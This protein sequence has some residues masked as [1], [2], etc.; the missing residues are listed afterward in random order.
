[1]QPDRGILLLAAASLPDPNFDHT[2]VLL[3]DHADEQGSFGLVL[4]HRTTVKLRDVIEGEGEWNAP[5]YRGGPVQLNSLHF[6]HRGCDQ[7]PEA[8]ELV[9]GLYWGR[10]FDSVREAFDKG[11]ADPADF[12][13]F[14]GYSGWG[15]QQL[16]GELKQES[17]Y[18][19]QATAELVFDE[20]IKN[21]WRNAFRTLGP[22]YSILSTFPDNCMLN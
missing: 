14:A 20:D 10:D 11:S 8:I 2:V 16:S 3:C 17:W 7:D 19:A 1:M 6:L 22:D 15:E 5:L 4:N 21:Q 12:R 13:F 18:L 9:E